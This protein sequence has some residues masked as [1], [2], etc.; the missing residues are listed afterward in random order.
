MRNKDAHFAFF[1]SY[2]RA[3]S[4][5]DN[6]IYGRLVR[7]MSEYYFNEESPNLDSPTDLLAWDLIEPILSKGKKNL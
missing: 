5:L 3:L 7:A 1:E 2:H 4:R 6:E